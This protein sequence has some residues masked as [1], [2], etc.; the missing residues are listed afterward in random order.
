M[1]NKIEIRRVFLCEAIIAHSAVATEILQA[2][3]L[4]LRQTPQ[5][6]PAATAAA[7]TAAFTAK[8]QAT[9]LPLQ[10]AGFMNR[11]LLQAFSKISLQATRHDSIRKPT[12][13]YAI[14]HRN[15]PRCHRDPLRLADLYHRR[16]ARP[17]RSYS[18]CV[19]DYF[20]RKHIPP[21]LVR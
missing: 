5:S 9:R 7:N 19:G 3:R 18:P 6:T 4:S 8:L 17:G 13:K 12:K 15:H 11:S 21:D 1:R 16:T 10:L 2:T 20:R 14:Q